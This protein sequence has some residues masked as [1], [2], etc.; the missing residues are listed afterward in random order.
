MIG[1][2][3]MQALAGRE[4]ASEA[5]AEL[6]GRN[7]SMLKGI[8]QQAERRAKDRI[9]EDNPAARRE[10]GDSLP[11]CGRPGVWTAGGDPL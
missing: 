4:M 6:R 5:W 1:S 11:Q 3:V 10:Q 7:V 8:E 9:L 2:K